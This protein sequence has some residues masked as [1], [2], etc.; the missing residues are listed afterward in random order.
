MSVCRKV[1]I[2][3]STL[4]LGC[5]PGIFAKIHGIFESTAV[6]KCHDNF[7]AVDSGERQIAYFNCNQN[8]VCLMS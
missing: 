6:S 8:S 4:K 1:M 7:I 3:S 2:L 5:R